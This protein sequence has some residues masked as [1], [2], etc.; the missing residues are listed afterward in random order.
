M[1]LGQPIV[2]HI[3][4]GD[5][6]G[7]WHG[8]EYINLYADRQN[9]D[10]DANGGNAQNCVHSLNTTGLEVGDDP[11]AFVRGEVQEWADESGG[12]Y[13]NAGWGA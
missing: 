3:E 11:E 2:V 7:V 6:Y 10:L 8:G 9:A 12:D 5:W 1:K 4:R 13:R